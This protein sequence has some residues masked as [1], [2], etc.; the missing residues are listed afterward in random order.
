MLKVVT[1][2]LTAYNKIKNTKQTN[3]QK[4]TLEAAKLTTLISP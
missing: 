4:E 2:E 3:E 1:T